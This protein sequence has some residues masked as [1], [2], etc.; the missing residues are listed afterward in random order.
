MTFNEPMTGIS[1]G[2]MRSGKTEPFT[3]ADIER[4]LRTSDFTIKRVSRAN[5]GKAR[6]VTA[7]GNRHE[8]RAAAA[9]ARR[10]KR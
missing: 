3:I 1:Y 9:R 8:R 6:T 7:T 5:A 4:F 10:A 2:G